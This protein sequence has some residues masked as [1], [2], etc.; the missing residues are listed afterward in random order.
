MAMQARISAAAIAAVAGLLTCLALNVRCQ[1]TTI[2][3]AGTT[4]KRG[5]T[6]TGAG[7]FHVCLC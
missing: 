3:Y 2:D 4:Q 5:G 1:T 6:G 7:E